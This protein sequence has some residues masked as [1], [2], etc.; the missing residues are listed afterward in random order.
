[1]IT[2]KRYAVELSPVW[3]DFIKEARNGLFLFDR[4]YMDYHSDRFT[5]HSLLFYKEDELLAVLPATKQGNTLNSHA[6]LTY[7]GFVLSKRAGADFLLKLFTFLKSYLK[8][9]GDRKSVV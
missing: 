8:E 7:G 9:N 6:G 3:N 5:D 1:M 2:I 4:N